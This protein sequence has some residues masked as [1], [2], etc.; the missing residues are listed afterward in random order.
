HLSEA[1]AATVAQHIDTCSA[2]QQALDNLS[3]DGNTRT[4]RRLRNLQPQAGDEPRPDFMRRLGGVLASGSA[5]AR[6]AMEST[7]PRASSHR[8]GPHPTPEGYEILERRGRGGMGVVYKAR[9]L[10]LKRTVALKMLLTGVEAGSDDRARLLTEAE[11]VARLQH[12][13]IVQIH[14]IGER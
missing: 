14:E 9:D 10:R 11:A 1:D 3:A 8:S 12:P 6:A 7:R 5:L 13:N 4:W 2:C